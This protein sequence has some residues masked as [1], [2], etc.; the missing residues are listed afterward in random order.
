MTRFLQE[1]FD[2][3][4]RLIAMESGSTVTNTTDT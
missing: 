3:T 1:H 2:E 4:L